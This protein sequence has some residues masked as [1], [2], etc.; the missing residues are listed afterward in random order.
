[1]RHFKQTLRLIIYILTIAFLATLSSCDR[2][3][4]KGHQV[5]D[6]TQEKIGETK[7]KISDKKNKLVDKVFPTY[8]NSKPDTENNKKRFKEHLQ[9]DLTDDVKNIYAYG[10]FFGADYK[11]LISFSCDTATLNKI[12]KA[13]GMTIS[14]TD[15]DEGLLFLDEFSWWDKKVIAKIR[16]LKV[17][18]EYE[19]WQYLWFDKKSKNAYYEEFS[20]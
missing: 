1:M 4:R 5:V 13:K 9:V 12:V 16:P 17:G 7:Q 10:D 15:N 3:K 2:L 11:V 6:K 14:T 20:L 8:D 18:K 19:Y